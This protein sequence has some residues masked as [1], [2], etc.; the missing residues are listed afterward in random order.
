LDRVAQGRILGYIENRTDAVEY[1]RFHALS[2][3][4]HVNPDYDRMCSRAPA[5]VEGFVSQV[6]SHIDVDPEQRY[7]VIRYDVESR[8][9][10]N[11]EDDLLDDEFSDNVNYAALARAC[12]KNPELCDLFSDMLAEGK[13]GSLP[14]LEAAL[15]EL[16]LRTNEYGGK[17]INPANL[18]V[19]SAA[20]AIAARVERGWDDIFP[21][22]VVPKGLQAQEHAGY[23]LSHII[24]QRSKDGTIGENRGQFTEPAF[25]DKLLNAL[26]R[27]RFHSPSMRFPDTH[28]LLV[29]DVDAGSE[30]SFVFIVA[31]MG[32]V[33]ELI[34]GMYFPDR[35]ELDRYLA[36]QIDRG[37]AST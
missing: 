10:F 26:G 37:K 16:S 18:K 30:A 31:R 14:E 13:V 11:A 23:G 3:G 19:L 27:A 17:V 28:S 36:L 12:A 15:R 21:V 22:I 6:V 29:A 1:A 4:L 33:H 9:Q 5:N 35:A 20:S 24:H 8:E 2:L 7:S 32:D 25:V 34:S